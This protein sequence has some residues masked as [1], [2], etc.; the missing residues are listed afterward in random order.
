MAMHVTTACDWK[1]V[2][3]H[4]VN[5]RLSIKR[6]SQCLRSTKR[7]LLLSNAHLIHKET[8]IQIHKILCANAKIKICDVFTGIQNDFELHFIAV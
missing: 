2:A 4:S 8:R 7:Q 1:C 6:S 5:W 3:I